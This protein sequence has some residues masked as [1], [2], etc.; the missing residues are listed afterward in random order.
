MFNPSASQIVPTAATQPVS[1]SFLRSVLGTPSAPLIYLDGNGHWTTTRP[2]SQAPA[3][4][5][6]PETYVILRAGGT[7]SP[8]GEGWTAPSGASFRLVAITDVAGAHH[9]IAVTVGPTDPPPV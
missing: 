5:I 2:S 6:S 8:Q 3:F 9:G 1:S 4:R 7:P